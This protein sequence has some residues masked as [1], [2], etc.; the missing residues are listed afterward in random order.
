MA[1][2]QG[3]IKKTSREDFTNI[4]RS[5]LKA[6]TLK[7]SDTLEWVSTSTGKDAILLTTASG[8]AIHFSEK[9]VLPVFLSLAQS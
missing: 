9:D 6:I 2:R 5:G 3:I 4:R 8:Q 7:D 1:T